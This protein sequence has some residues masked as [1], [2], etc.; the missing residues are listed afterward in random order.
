MKVS[1]KSLEL[2]VGAEL[3]N[4]MRNDFGM[5]KAYLR[6]LTQRE[7][8]QEGV[9]FF[10][11]LG[12]RA[13]FF[14]FQFKAPKGNSDGSPYRYT[15]Q[16]EQHDALFNLAQS[17]SNSVFYV[18]PHYVTTVKLQQDV[19]NLMNDTWLLSIDQMSPAGVFGTAKSKTVRCERTRAIINPEYGMHRVQDAALR[20]AV[21]RGGVRAREIQ[22]WYSRFRASS[23][24][25]RRS[26]W[27]TRGLL[28][29]VVL[30]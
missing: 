11:R 12:L 10:L 13:R 8:K 30:P 25:A 26:P 23:V 5:T 28:I 9:D 27:L 6:G 7:E 3:L 15:I 29:A 22:Q 14:A 20:A 18:F 21:I 4:Q 16:R 24:V 1:E 17:A 2:N 19:P